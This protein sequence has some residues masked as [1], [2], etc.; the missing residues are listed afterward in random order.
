MMSH[1]VIEN[2]NLAITIIKFPP[3][4]TSLENNRHNL[5]D[6]KLIVNE[7]IETIKFESTDVTSIKS[8]DSYSI[9]TISSSSSIIAS[10][11]DG[12]NVQ[13]SSSPSISDIK[14][15]TSIESVPFVIHDSCPNETTLHDEKSESTISCVSQKT[16]ENLS[17]CKNFK[18]T[19]SLKS[20]LE[21]FQTEAE[22]IFFNELLAVCKVDSSSVDETNNSNFD[23]TKRNNSFLGEISIN[24]E[25]RQ[26]NFE[27][28]VT[29]EFCMEASYAKNIIYSVSDKKFNLIEEKR[30]ESYELDGVKMVIESK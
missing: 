9:S 21:A 20:V 1:E 5:N 14:Q 12:E 17:Q 10:C 11:W 26:N 8:P 18:I 2:K 24:I 13:H 27:A 22:H 16:Q 6:F 4:I 28:F 23:L 19:Q 15:I 30:V 29:S 3:G 25:S 7:I